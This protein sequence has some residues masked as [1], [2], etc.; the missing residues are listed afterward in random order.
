VKSNNFIHRHPVLT[1]FILV[2]A[3]TW[4]AV[5]LIAQALPPADTADSTTRIAVLSLPMLLAPGLTAVLLTL[6]LEG[7][8]GLK[9]LLSGMG[10]RRVDG[11]WYFVALL[12]MPVLVLAILR[13]LSVVISPGFTPILSLM[14]LAG[15]A[16]G[17]LEEI[18]WTGFAIPRLST[19]MRPLLVGL[20][21]GVLWALWHALADYSIRGETLGSFW[22]ITFG[23][24][25]IPLVAWRMLMLWVYDN[26]R[27][28]LLA[29]LMHFSYTG[30]LALFVPVL[31]KG[32]DALVYLLL[33]IAL[34]SGV[35]VLAAGLRRS[36]SP[37]PS[38]LGDLQSL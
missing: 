32:E 16:A 19:R 33:S 13:L 2:F 38:Q 18:G 14:G 12:V 15:I 29:Q 5:F 35:A 36:G 24:F 9:K 22:S 4:G 30:S 34:W 11:R 1:Y 25:A 7:R 17:F 8:A 28:L 27:S 20:V 26:T 21:V 10:R 3:L 6:H 37:M 23:L 31:S